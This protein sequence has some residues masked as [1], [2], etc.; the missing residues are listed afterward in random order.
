MLCDFSRQACECDAC[1]ITVTIAQAVMTRMAPSNVSAYL[2]ENGAVRFR[3]LLPP[4]SPLRMTSASA[5]LQVIRDHLE[6]AV[7][8]QARCK[9][10]F[11]PPPKRG[12]LCPADRRGFAYA[13]KNGRFD[14]LES[15]LDDDVRR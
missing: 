14:V 12:F 15:K 9:I 13:W 4:E 3:T 11:F 10:T 8:N 5:S 6:Q 2:F 7:K 1:E